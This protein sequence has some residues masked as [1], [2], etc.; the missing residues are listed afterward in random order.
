[1]FRDISE[2]GLAC[3]ILTLRSSRFR[4]LNLVGEFMKMHTLTL[5]FSSSLTSFQENCFSCMPNLMCLSM[6]E[7]RIS[8]LWTTVAAL[9]KLPSLVELRFQYW[10]CCNDAMTSYV[11]SSGK[12]DGTADFILPKRVPYICESWIDMNELTDHNFSVDDPLSSFYSFDDVINHDVSSI[13]EDSSDDSEVDFSS[14]HQRYWLSAVFPR[15][16]GQVPH[17]NEVIDLAFLSE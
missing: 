6:C 14:H 5:D 12:S 8:N 11:S 9:S 15:W 13:V 10:L 3:Q 2:R 7:T 16:N 4:K 17:Q 1:M